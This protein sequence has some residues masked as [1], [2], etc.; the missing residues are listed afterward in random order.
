MNVV[1][2]RK[3]SAEDREGFH[4]AAEARMQ[5]IKYDMPVNPKRKEIIHLS[6]SDLMKVNM[7][8]LSDGGENNLH[9]HTGSDTTWY[10]VKGRVKFYGVGDEII[11]EFGENEGI[12]IPGGARYWFEKTGEGDLQLLQMVAIDR[13]YPS[14]AERIN[15]D[16][17]K[18][19]MQ[20]D[21][22]K[23]Y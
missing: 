5:P 4:Q 22:L 8:V 6:K 14:K 17:H 15:I 9:Y 7:Q 23:V 1:D 2:V 20:G 11:G 3:M 16:A 12:F 13:T 18:D 19:W 10:V 21:H